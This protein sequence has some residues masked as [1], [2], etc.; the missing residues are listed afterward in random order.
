MS[1]KYIPLEIA[2]LYQDLFNHMSQE[3]GLTLTISQMDDIIS[4]CKKLNTKLK[5]ELEKM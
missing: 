2:D 5:Q 1:E 4:E 3:H